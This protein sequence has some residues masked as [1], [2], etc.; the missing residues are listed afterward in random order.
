MADCRLTQT[1]A[2]TTSSLTWTVGTSVGWMNAVAPLM[3]G[4]FEWN[5]DVLM[6]K[7]GEGLARRIGAQVTH[8]EGSAPPLAVAVAPPLVATAIAGWTMRRLVK[9]IARS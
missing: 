6:K 2:R 7:A 3:R 8:R 5:H 9:T 1:G 4:L